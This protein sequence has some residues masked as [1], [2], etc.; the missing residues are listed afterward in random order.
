MTLDARAGRGPGGRPPRCGC[1]A[2]P[3]APPRAARRRDAPEPRPSPV[4]L[5]AP[6]VV[7]GLHLDG[8]VRDLVLEQERRAPGRAR[9]ARRR[10]APIITCALATSISDVSVHTWRS[11]TSTTPGS[12]S[13]SRRIASRSTCSGATCSS[14]RSA[15]A[16]E[17]PRARQ[18]PDADHRG[19]DRVDRI[20]ARRRDHDRGDDHADRAGGVGHRV[21][22]GAA[23]REA[24]LRAGRAA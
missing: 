2:A 14:T 8:G 18:D 20:P 6:C 22:V 19:D 7:V 21:D 15:L 10:R 24:V 23:H 17:P 13:S 1:A 5:G 12:A 9:R 16:A 4:E 3:R 11:C